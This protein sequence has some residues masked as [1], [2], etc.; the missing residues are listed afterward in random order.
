[1]QKRSKEQIIS[2]ILEICCEG[3][4]KTAIIYKT[5]SNSTN[6]S[7]YLRLLTKNKLVRA[8]RREYITTS[9]GIE[10]LDNLKKIQAALGGINS[11]PI[12]CE[13]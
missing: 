9:K 12:K 1:M 8:N 7:T 6:V 2:E 3:A 13:I 4:N 11:Q 10:M 5:S